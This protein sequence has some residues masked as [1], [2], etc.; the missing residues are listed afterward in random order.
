MS[1]FL[2]ARTAL[3]VLVGLTVL[4]ALVRFF[5]QSTILGTTATI[6]VVGT[7]FAGGG[8]YL[9]DAYEGDPRREQLATKIRAIGFILI[10]L[11]TLFGALMLLL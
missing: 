8:M 3:F 11:G 6:V 10:G 9:E 5:E 7:G 1:R 4:I 2:N